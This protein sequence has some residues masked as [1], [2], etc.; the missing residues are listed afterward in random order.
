MTLT[1]PA[2]ALSIDSTELSIGGIGPGV[3]EASVLKKLGK[4]LRRLDTGEG[5]DLQ[6]P[7][8]VV[9]VG[10]LEEAGPGRRR[11]VFALH[12]TGPKACTPGG[13]CPGMPVTAA[14]RMYG[15]TE[16][17]RR[18]TGEFYEYQPNGWS[19]WLQISAPEG[20][21]KSLAVACQP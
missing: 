11:R 15:R 19:C 2:A 7:S 9:S 21:I 17:V 14:M 13:L 8:L 20:I 12:G 10:W 5:I 16:T 4:P 3:T 6:Y 18:E 1:A